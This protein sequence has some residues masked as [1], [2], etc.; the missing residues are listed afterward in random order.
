MR[1][2]LRSRPLSCALVVLLTLALGLCA[3]STGHAQS[4]INV[5][6]HTGWNPWTTNG[7]TLLTDPLGDQQTGQG[8]D[9]FV[10]D[11]TYYGYAQKA[12]TLNG[13]DTFMFRA[14]FNKFDGTNQWGGNGGNIGVGLDL[15]GNGSIDLVMVMV[16]SSGNVNNRTRT[17]YF[18]S[19]GTGANTGPST[20]TWTIDTSGTAIK[21]T[22]T[23][24]NGSNGGT[25]S[26]S[27]VQ[28]TDGSAFGGTPDSWLT[29]AVSFQTLQ[30]AIRKY[31]RDSN[32]NI[33]V[34]SIFANW[35]VNYTTRISFIG[36]TSTQLNA[37]NQDLFGTSGNNSST[38]TWNQ[39]GV[40]TPMQDAYGIVPEPAT[41][42]QLG[43]LL[44]AGTFVAYRRKR[45]ATSASALRSST[46]A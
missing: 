13:T 22:L 33:G 11:S 2:A 27:L 31:A 32:G 28:T 20:T 18:G 4:P 19:P 36:Y 45:R 43:A 8:Q 23:A 14:R 12:G 26:Y 29:F 25:A 37:L 44:L 35:T 7:T 6:D 41:Y 9:D 42:A 34:N 46:G 5:A 17:V 3:V 38:L 16:E 24:Y 15:D 40:S 21:Q 39:L 30:D 10:G 1:H